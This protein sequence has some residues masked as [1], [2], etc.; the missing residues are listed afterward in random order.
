L[1]DVSYYKDNLNLYKNWYGFTSRFYRDN[2]SSKSILKNGTKIAMGSYEINGVI[3]IALNDLGDSFE[4]FT[5][6]FNKLD[7]IPRDINLIIGKNG[8]GKHTYLKRCVM[9]LLV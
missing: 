9:S 7:D 6:S 4:P 2:S 1:C 8:L 5:L 3:E